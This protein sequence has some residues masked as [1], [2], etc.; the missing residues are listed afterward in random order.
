MSAARPGG[1]FWVLASDEDEEEAEGGK[2][3]ASA[4][5]CSSYST[6]AFFQGR[7]DE[8]SAGHADTTKIQAGQS[9]TDR[10]PQTTSSAVRPWRGPLP[11]VVLPKLTV[12][13]C[14]LPSSWTMVR[15]K[16]KTQSPAVTAPAP[17]IQIAEQRCLRLRSLLG[18]TTD[19]YFEPVVGLED[20]GY[21]AQ[22]EAQAELQPVSCS[23]RESDAPGIGSGQITSDV[24]P[25]QFVLSPR[26]RPRRNLQDFLVSPRVGRLVFLPCKRKESCKRNVATFASRLTR[27][28]VKQRRRRRECRP[29]RAEAIPHMLEC[30]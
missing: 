14:I 8:E 15:N 20:T 18:P 22:P 25:V 9:L 27:L 7:S 10:V 26:V 19:R 17:A 5:V 6:D 29:W 16:R 2:I 23:D 13:D 12:S 1:R 21:T 28:H 4:E 24:S 30:R 3:I 11:R